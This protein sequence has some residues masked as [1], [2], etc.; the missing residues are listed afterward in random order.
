MN[1]GRDGN[2]RE[3]LGQARAIHFAMTH[4]QLSYKEAKIR[5]KPL[6][7]KI[8]K[9]T[10]VIAKKYHQKPKIITFNDLGRNF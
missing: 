9:E 6:L 4:E 2:L 7:Q 5:T 8:N 3:L 10:E 1:S